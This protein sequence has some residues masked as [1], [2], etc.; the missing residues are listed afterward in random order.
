MDSQSRSSQGHPSR[1]HGSSTFPA[2]ATSPALTGREVSSSP[3]ITSLPPIHTLHPDLPAHSVIMGHHGHGSS[4]TG[5]SPGSGST[6]G[7][8]PAPDDS[9]PEG[10]LPG[11]PKKKRRRQALSCTECKRRKIKCDRAQPCGPCS[12]RGE[13]HRCQWHIIEPMEKY[14]TRG[15]YDELKSRF[16]ELEAL[17]YRALP[18]LHASIPPIQGGTSVPMTAVPVSEQ[19]QGAAITP[20]HPLSNVPVYHH[21]MSSPRSPG[22]GEPPQASRASATPRSPVSQYRPSATHST[23]SGRSFLPPH[24]AHPPSPRQPPPSPTAVAPASRLP[25]PQPPPQ[26]P[27]S[28]RSS[29]S[30]AAITTPY[31]PDTMPRNQ[32][33]NPEAQTL[34]WPGQRLRSAPT[35]TGPAPEHNFHLPPILTDLPSAAAQ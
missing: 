34:P 4:M 18:G 33:K 35:P 30:L 7:T 15:E 25:P 16:E 10:D 27:T 3:Q 20:Y 23:S 19:A 2:S 26:K 29:L 24:P 21:M 6:L 14:V 11:P 32:P 13:Q 31:T 17:V 5:Y 12:R 28:R 8:R 9:D 22:R 1:G